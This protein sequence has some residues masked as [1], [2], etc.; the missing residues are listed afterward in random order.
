M[1]LGDRAVAPIDDAQPALVPRENAAAHRPVA[2][3][4]ATAGLTLL[5][6]CALWGLNFVAIKVGNNGFPPMLAAALRSV[7]AAVLIGVWAVARRQRLGGPPRLLLH[8]T[9]TGFLFA[10][11]FIFLY[12]GTSYTSASRATLLVYTSPFWVALGAHWLLPGDRLRAVKIG[13]LALSFLGVLAV[14]RAPGGGLAPSHLRG[15]V[16]EVCAAISWAA[17]TLYIKRFIQPF[18]VSPLQTL[19]YQVAFSA[20]LLV[21]AAVVA[22]QAQPEAWRL[23]SVLALVYQTVVVATFSYLVWFWLLQRNQASA[24]HSFTFFAP[25]FGVI[26][27]GF[28]LGD[29]L[30]L[31]LWAGLALV[32]AG[33]YLVNRSPRRGSTARA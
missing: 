33:T 23:D 27:A 3:L 22:G 1:E 6:L 12:A 8:G 7:G 11:E 2:G 18:G 13:G 9:V 17:T 28:L 5:S 10:L 29:H 20:P 30:P 4:S 16:L 32:A 25:L 15:D 31:L 21:F 19:F 14:F 26:F 24:L